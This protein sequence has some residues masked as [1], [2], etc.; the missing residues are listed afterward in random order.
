MEPEE[1]TD[2]SIAYYRKH[3]PQRAQ[4]RI[5]LQA[6]K[7]ILMEMIENYLSRSEMETWMAEHH[8]ALGFALPSTETLKKWLSS[9]RKEIGKPLRVRQP[10]S[11]PTSAGTLGHDIVASPTRVEKPSTTVSQMEVSPPPGSRMAQ[12]ASAH[13]PQKAAT[14]TGA[15]SQGY[16]GI[17]EILEDGVKTIK[18]QK[19][20]IKV[21]KPR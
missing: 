20:A 4:A 5:G 10:A 18:P 13:S 1:L 19:K 3:A 15:E 6:W 14:G 7:P 12:K 8:T 21:H 2:E 9:I 11:P 16:A 17:N